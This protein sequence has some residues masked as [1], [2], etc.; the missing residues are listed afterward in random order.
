MKLTEMRV[1]AA[2]CG[3]I[4]LGSIVWASSQERGKL[5]EAYRAA[6]RDSFGTDVT[7]DI[8]KALH[9]NGEDV[10][11]FAQSSG[12]TCDRSSYVQDRAI[13]LCSRYAWGFFDPPFLKRERWVF[14]VECKEIRPL[15]AV[16]KHR[17][18]ASNAPLF[19]SY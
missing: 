8:A 10:I 7:D 16:G 6:W 17:G 4:L 18:Q 12:F 11:A 15:C 9:R 13:W 1:Y 5:D 3:V 2:W 14:E 19:S